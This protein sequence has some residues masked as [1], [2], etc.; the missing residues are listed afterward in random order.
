[1]EWKYKELEQIEMQYGKY[2]WIDD[3][4]GYTP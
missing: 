3:M 1:M 2:R 4:N